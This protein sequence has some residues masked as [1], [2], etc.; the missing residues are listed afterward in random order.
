MTFLKT[1]FPRLKPNIADYKD[2]LNDYIRSELLK[3]IDRSDSH[4]SNFKDLQYTL[5]IVLDKHAPLE[6]RF[7]RTNQQNF[8]DKELR[9]KSNYHS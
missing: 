4:I 8:M 9:T 2:S 1:H 3:E 6:K 5:Q 7:V